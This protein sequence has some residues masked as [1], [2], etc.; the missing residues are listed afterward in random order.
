[1]S[2]GVQGVDLEGRTELHRIALVIVDNPQT[3]GILRHKLCFEA[4]G[5]IISTIG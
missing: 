1:M 5:P 3:N 2:G 4:D